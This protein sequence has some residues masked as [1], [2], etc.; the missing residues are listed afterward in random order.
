VVA[1]STLCCLQLRPS[2]VSSQPAARRSPTTTSTSFSPPR[3]LVAAPKAAAGTSTACGRAETETAPVR[4]AISQQD[5][6]TGQFT[7]TTTTTTLPPA[8]WIRRV[9]R[10]MTVCTSVALRQ[11]SR[12]TRDVANSHLTLMT[13]LPEDRRDAELPWPTICRTASAATTNSTTTN[14]DR[15]VS[16]TRYPMKYC[17][18]DEVD[19]NL[20]P[21]TAEERLVV[22]MDDEERQMSF[23][24]TT[25]GRRRQRSRKKIYS[26]IIDGRTK[27]T[28]EVASGPIVDELTTL[29]TSQLTVS[30]PTVCWTRKAGTKKPL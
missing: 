20:P 22:A 9:Q 25:T 16:M 2:S 6:A 24:T 23:G 13:S 15:I 29:T 26:R 12:V 21:T 17:P 10:A 3:R 14:N 28:V 27:W 30:R 1:A 4:H 5:V 8:I 7:P 18:N 19:P 11:Q